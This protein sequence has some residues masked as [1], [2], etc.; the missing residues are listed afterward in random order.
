M[1]RP[2][3]CGLQL[4]HEGTPHPRPTLP[5]PLAPAAD[6]WIALAGPLTHIPQFLVWFAILFPVYHAAYGRCGQRAARAAV[7]LLA[8]SS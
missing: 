3:D 2:T 6:L 7:C 4:P 8:R 1:R 5:Q